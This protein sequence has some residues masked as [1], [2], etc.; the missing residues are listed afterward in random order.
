[1]PNYRQVL[2]VNLKEQNCQQEH[3]HKMNGHVQ[4]KHS[5]YHNP[6]RHHSMHPTRYGRQEVADRQHHDRK[7]HLYRDAGQIQ[8]I[9]ELYLKEP[10]V[11][12]LVKQREAGHGNEVPKHMP[13]PA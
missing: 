7:K 9:F 8:R 3:R 1:M 10:V 2:L 13:E 12:P 6:N 5:R 4:R 11:V